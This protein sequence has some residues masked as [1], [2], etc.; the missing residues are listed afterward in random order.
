MTQRYTVAFL[1]SVVSA[2]LV[3][4]LCGMWANPHGRVT[5]SETFSDVSQAGYSVVPFCLAFLMGHAFGWRELPTIVVAY[6]CGAYF[7]PTETRGGT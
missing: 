1:L 2:C 4:N 7:W 3:W 5:L 6:I